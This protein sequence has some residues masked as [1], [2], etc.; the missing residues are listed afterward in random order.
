MR[1]HSFTLWMGGATTV[2]SLFGCG[3]GIVTNGEAEHCGA[4]RCAAQGKNCGEL[5]VEGCGVVHCGHCQE[6]ETCGGGGVPNVCA[7]ETCTPPCVDTT[8]PS[9]LITSPASGSTVATSTV[10]VSGTASDDVA[11]AR[12]E[13]RMGAGAY[14]LASGTIS[15]SKQVTLPAGSNTIYAKATDTSGNANE[16]SVAVTYSTAPACGNHVV[17]AGE[18]CDTNGHIGCGNPT[19]ICQADCQACVAPSVFI[20]PD[21]TISINGKRTFPIGMYYICSTTHDSKHGYESCVDSIALLPNFT[22]SQRGLPNDMLYWDANAPLF[23]SAGIS[24]TTDTVPSQIG[25]RKDEAYFFGYYQSP[26][27]PSTPAAYENLYSR[28]KAIK[29][30]DSSHP[31]MVS[32]WTYKPSGSTYDASEVADIIEEP[33]YT[34]KT[35]C[36]FTDRQMRVTD[37]AVFYYFL[38][39]FIFARE[40]SLKTNILS[41]AG[42]K[43]IEGIEKP[44]FMI[45]EGYGMDWVDGGNTWRVI[46]EN[47]L[48][49]YVY[50][51]ITAGYS[52]I[53]VWG[54]KF[55]GDGTTSFGLA[56]NKTIAAYYNNLA[57]ELTSPKI[58]NVLLLPTLNFS[59]NYDVAWDNKVT[60]SKNPIRATFGNWNGYALTYRLKYDATS[61]KYYLIVANKSNESVSPTIRISGLSG[62]RTAR[63]MGTTGT[64]SSAANREI[65]VKDGVFEDT[66]D[67]YAGH[68]YEIGWP[69]LLHQ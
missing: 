69:S 44:L 11:V 38:D 7:P 17:D 10:T 24:Y 33:L 30:G 6:A 54:Y 26:E 51:A 55:W 14:D 27:E 52:G 60:F 64:G 23:A 39:D 65:T 8:P 13:V 25:I 46:P 9:V 68:V 61:D 37:C 3:T 42:T 50:W 12:I 1:T 36:G 53:D 66:F 35:N 16:T 31:V 18:T 63:T 57:G 29:A 32:S 58:Q 15:W 41:P 21:K 62:T 28:Y 67:A 22:Y 48:R 4:S 45:I 47:K 34:H 56:H 5:V 2:I 43:S 40:R 19:P 49:G 20:N 59:W